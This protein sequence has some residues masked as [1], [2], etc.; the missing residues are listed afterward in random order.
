MKR[1]HLSAYIAAITTEWERVDEMWGV[2]LARALGASGSVGIELFQ[3]VTGS[4]A[5]SAILKTGIRRAILHDADLLDRFDSLLKDYGKRSRERNR[6]VHA[7]WGYFKERDDVLVAAEGGWLARTHANANDM[8]READE[9]GSG[10]PDFRMPVTVY[11]KKD[12]EEILLRIRQVGGE[13]Q[14]FFYLMDRS[15]SEKAGMQLPSSVA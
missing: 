3:A 15:I 6:V 10:P 9:R 7:M 8:W 13:Q 4:A 12:F 11:S 5:Q 14:G 2:I 1:P